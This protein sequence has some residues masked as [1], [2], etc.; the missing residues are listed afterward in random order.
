M[1]RNFVELARS[2]RAAIPQHHRY[3]HS[4]RVARLAASLARAHG[5]DARRARLAG[6]LHDLARL[7]SADALLRE[8]ERRGLPIDPFERRHPIVLH[9]RLGAEL[10]RERYGIEDGEVLNA[11][12]RHT[13]AG[14]QMSRLDEILYLADGLEPGRTFAPRRAI[15]H[16][17]YRDVHQGMLSLLGATIEYQRQRGLEVAPQT[18]AALRWYAAPGV[19]DAAGKEGRMEDRFCRT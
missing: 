12:R 6:M 1:T 17:A 15:L 16:S 4:L 2:V 14:P 3:A 19:G 13:V 10:A 11:I 5:N 7:Q 18:L 9:A 8:C